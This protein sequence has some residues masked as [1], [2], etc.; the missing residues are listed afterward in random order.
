MRAAKALTRVQRS[1]QGTTCVRDENK[2]AV[3][4]TKAYLDR[5][6]SALYRDCSLFSRLLQESI[7]HVITH[8]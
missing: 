6:S 3:G 7:A 1:E 5:S 8:S 4:P 2:M